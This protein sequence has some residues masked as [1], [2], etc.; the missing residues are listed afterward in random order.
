M[1]KG[2]FEG[3][4]SDAFRNAE[5]SPG[6]DS[7]TNIALELEKANATG[8][9][10][11]ILVY[12]LLAA[13][14]VIF[15]L[16]IGFGMYRINERNE[17]LSREL[18]LLKEANASRIAQESVTA[19]TQSRKEPQAQQR[20]E[21][22]SV[23]GNADSQLIARTENQGD[24]ESNVNSN[25]INNFSRTK[26]L[27][28]ISK[29]NSS[30]E[31]IS[32]SAVLSSYN[33]KE[34]PQLYRPWV[35][36]INVRKSNPHVDPVALMLAQLDDREKEIRDASTNKDKKKTT[37]RLW[38]SLGLAAGAFNASNS[39]GVSS[40]ESNRVLAMNNSVAEK[41]A[42]ANGLAYSI[43]VS[44]GTKIS[45]RWVL[46]GGVNYMS[47]SSDYTV[48]N[49]VTNP[50]FDTFRPASINE[51]GK[52]NFADDVT[53]TDEKLIS[54]APYEVNNDLRY[55]SIP[56]QA[57][58]LVINQ[59]FGLQL[60]AGIATDLFLQNTISAENG[61]LET[62]RLESG[63]D[64]P[65]RSVNFS[66]L[67]GTEVS[68]RF[69]KHYRVSLNPGIRYPLNTIYKSEIG[70]DATPVTFDIGLR[71]RYIFN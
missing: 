60:N 17:I 62:T 47:Q 5:V 13:A 24:S 11:R 68:Y 40:T 4:V 32:E 22:Q 67:V 54:T 28:T 43:G 25:G 51:L 48:Q 30:E 23:T 59:A 1:E 35:P 42:S 29:D 14:S 49:A 55:L 61:N 18:A 21:E 44:L 70:V 66:G 63:D 65:Y 39:V 64:S 19:P 53:G 71:F 6:E 7:W 37:E 16:G 31:L 2:K 36:Q 3:S 33:E 46:Q 41:E 8:L 56:L 15:V 69:A 58:Y 12:K 50:E 38:T 26:N 20:I 34:F 57:G 52:M 9:R 27:F 45:E 10:R